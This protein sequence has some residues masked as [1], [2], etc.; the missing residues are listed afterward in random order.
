MHM[1]QIISFEK[2]IPFK[3]MI[4]EI[5]SISLEHTLKFE[6]ESSILGDFIVS[7]TYKMT[8]ASRLDEEFSYKIP[9][10]ILLTESLEEEGRSVEIDNFTYEIVDE[11]ALRVQIDL[12][13][14]GLEKIEIDKEATKEEEIEVL[15]M[16]EKP[17]EE[18]IARKIE[19]ADTV[20]EVCDAVV[21]KEDGKEEVTPEETRALEKD[22]L[23]EDIL[24]KNVEVVATNQTSST[25]DGEKTVQEAQENIDKLSENTKQILSEDE[26]SEQ[27][28][29][30]EKPSNKAM[31][32]SIFSAFK[33]T[34][35]TF[36]TY[37]IYILR[38][39]DTL[40]A[41]LSRYGISKEEAAQYNSLEELRVGS[42][43][44]LPTVMKDE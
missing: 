16:E 25:L 17:L 26:V 33:D 5:T 11:E 12:L 31:M 10:D 44:I 36:S 7:G 6:D 14:E 15:T 13:V 30:E 9:V 34:D 42:K 19:V 20:E 2:E 37:S 35:E 38:E 32:N 1:K 29:Q 8:E 23:K 18:P 39:E 24:R 4:G 27:V 3:T 21:E 28:N 43:L 22:E 41:I 40:D